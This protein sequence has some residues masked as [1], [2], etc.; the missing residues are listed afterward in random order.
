MTYNCFRGF[1]RGEQ[2]LKLGRL[3]WGWEVG[4]DGSDGSSSSNSGLEAAETVVDPP[5]EG[6]GEDATAHWDFTGELL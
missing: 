5:G 6:G 3:G 1:L 2:L 4:A